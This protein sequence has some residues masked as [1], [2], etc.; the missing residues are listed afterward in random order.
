[1]AKFKKFFKK[2]SEG[3]IVYGENIVNNIVDL[4]L[5]EIDL[6]KPYYQKKNMYDKNVTVVIEKDTV[7]VNVYVKI[8]YSTSISEMAFKVQEAIRHNVESMT[9]YRVLAINVHVLGVYFDQEEVAT[10]AALQEQPT[11]ENNEIKAN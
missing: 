8:H 5:S 3:K 7:T 2:K 10:P 11:K 4:A 6:V 1:M 9:P